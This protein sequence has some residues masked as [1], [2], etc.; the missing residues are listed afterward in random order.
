MCF[1]SEKVVALAPKRHCGSFYYVCVR[2]SGI[3][4]TGTCAA[5][6]TEINQHLE[7]VKN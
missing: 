3:W 5:T 2:G 1:V 7:S 6:F 4:R